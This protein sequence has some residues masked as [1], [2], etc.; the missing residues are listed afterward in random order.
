[1]TEIVRL[2]FRKG[3]AADWTAANPILLLGEPGFE[4]DT[5]EYKFGDG[6][7]NW[8]G[9]P[10]FSR[11]KRGIVIVLAAGW[12]PTATGPDTAEVPVPYSPADGTTSVTWNVRRIELRVSTAGGAPSVTI[13]KSTAT[14]LFSA[15]TVGT[16]TL[17]VGAYQGAVTA[18]LGTVASGTKLR[19][20]IGDLGSGAVGWSCTVLL[21]E[22]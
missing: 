10:Y 17:G 21:G 14:G 7:T 19:M 22:S 15:T 8:V 16:V 5:G 18:A 20:N 6:V 11:P 9:L 1:M 4:T 2:Q 12:D 3:T 13:E